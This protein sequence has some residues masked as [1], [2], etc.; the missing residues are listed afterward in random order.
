MA[1]PRP[2]LFALIGAVLLGAAFFATQV[3]AG[4]GAG[5]PG[6]PAPP[7]ADTASV[8]APGSPRPGKPAP[9]PKKPGALSGKAIPASRALQ[10]GKVVVLLFVQRDAADDDATARALRALK[11]GGS[12]AAVFVDRIENVADY[13]PL[14]AT[15]GISQAPS[16]V[17]AD[18]K[19]R[20]RVLE[21]YQDE[22]TLR[23]S[24]RDATR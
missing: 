12:P 16:V 17:I 13:G 8:P 15:L 19:R 3:M 11:S 21:G 1:L 14:A 2:L 23:Q 10:E 5:E 18:G 20:A 9:A 7:S 4:G 6:R 22:G 24:V